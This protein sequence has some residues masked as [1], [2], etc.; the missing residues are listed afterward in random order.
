MNTGEVGWRY[1]PRVPISVASG[2]E[3]HFSFFDVDPAFS[4]DADPD[5]APHQSDSNLIPLVYSPSAA[6]F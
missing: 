1:S 2:S 5:P 4:F 6:P 3:S